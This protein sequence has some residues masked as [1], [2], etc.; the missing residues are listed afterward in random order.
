MERS[1][2]SSGSNWFTPSVFFHSTVLF[3]MPPHGFLL[4]FWCLLA[5]SKQ[6]YGTLLPPTDECGSGQP[7]WKQT[8]SEVVL[9]YWNIS[10]RTSPSTRSW[11]NTCFWCIHV[12]IT[13]HIHDA[14]FSCKGLHCCEAQLV[15][16]KRE[17]T[18]KVACLCINI[19]EQL[20]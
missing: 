17:A 19:T 18:Y 6:L 5:V 20:L 8:P 14:G 3:E 9:C 13:T 11:T 15:I 4:L 2:G 7:T 16:S 1:L 12:S 10:I